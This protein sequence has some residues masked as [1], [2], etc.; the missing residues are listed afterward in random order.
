MQPISLR[1]ASNSLYIEDRHLENEKIYIELAKIFHYRKIRS[2]EFK[3]GVPR[4]ELEL[5]V[6][7]LAISPRNIIA[8]G[9]PESLFQDKLVFIEIEELDYSELLKGEG[10]EIKDL[11]VKILE[12]ALEEDDKEKIKELSKSF[13]KVIQAFD[14]MQI[15]SEDKLIDIFSEYFRSLESVDKSKFHDCS[16]D[17][18]KAFMEKKDELQH[19][20]IEKLT[21]ITSYFQEKDFA[22][23]FWEEVLV[24]ENFNTLEFN[25]LSRFITKNRQDKVAFSISSLFKKNEALNSNPEVKKKIEELLSTSA[26]P[27]ISEVYRNT[28]A[29]LLMDIKY[30]GTMS[31]DQNQLIK[32]YTF[33]LLN[34]VHDEKDRNQIDHLLHTFMKWW[35]HIR[36]EQDYECMKSLYQ[37][38]SEKKQEMGLNSDYSDIMLEL[39]SFIEKAVL[40]GELSLYFEYFINNF[41]HS[42]FDVNAYL[43]GIFQQGCVTPY[44]L[45]A[46]FKF[47]KEYLFYFNLNLSENVSDNRLMENII[48]CM[49]IIEPAL[50]LV[51]LKSIF[52]NCNKRLRVKIVQAMKT[53]SLYEESFLIPL[54]KENDPYLRGEA[55][56]L[57]VQHSDVKKRVLKSFLAFRS[58]FGLKNRLLMENLIII[59]KA[60][61]IDALPYVSFLSKKRMF[62]NRNIRAYARNLLE[63]WNAV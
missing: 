23:S 54:T 44:T 31:F 37:I 3:V 32:N 46:F 34:L 30:Q 41:E 15:I 59:A 47:H 22:S 33:I 12:Q 17:F 10:D 40:E 56:T 36:E 8:S 55:L 7:R 38:L 1:F 58:P 9:G 51:L 21:K 26:S 39:Q 28:L 45:K 13:S 5:F 53:Y 14:V 63:S 62:W 24:D 25:I 27:M 50:Q 52:E 61:L 11:W 42:V 19:A 35:E 49:E 29:R 48:N 18:L 60:E 57:L 16:K 2:M 6:S 20:N 4:K 43:E